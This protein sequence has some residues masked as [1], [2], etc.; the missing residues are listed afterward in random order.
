MNTKNITFDDLTDETDEDTDTA[1][2]EAL[3]DAGTWL[4]DLIAAVDHLRRGYRPN[5]TI[6]DALEEALRST[7]PSQHDDGGGG[8]TDET[9]WMHPDPLA[10]TLRHTLDTAEQPIAER[11]QQAI[12]H[13]VTINADHHNNGHYWPH[14]TAR[15]GFPPPRLN[16]DRYPY[17]PER[18]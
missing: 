4:L 13:W 11:F 10:A 9:I 12:R 2:T 17:G 18:T 6:W 1:A 3:G 5:L 16:F 15:R 7:N 8:D 14:P